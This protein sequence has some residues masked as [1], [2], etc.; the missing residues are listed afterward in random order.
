MDRKR[1]GNQITYEYFNETNVF[2]D[3]TYVFQ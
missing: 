2:K 3:N 1:N